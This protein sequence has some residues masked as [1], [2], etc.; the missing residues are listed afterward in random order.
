MRRREFIAGLGSA[1]A[2]PVV[3]R[4]QQP[5]MPVVAVLSGGGPDFINTDRMRAFREGLSD[6]GYIEGRNVMIE[7]CWASGRY[8]RLPEMATE[9]VRRQVAVIAALN[10]S[11]PGLA[12]KA[13]STRIPIV[14]QTGGDPVKDGLVANLNRP[15]GNVT[16]VSSMNAVQRNLLYTGITRGKRLVVLVGQKKAVA[17]AVRNVSGRRRWSKLSEWLHPSEPQSASWAGRSTAQRSTS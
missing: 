1:A 3:A 14:F 12:A 4:A 11:V 5:A 16:G 15:G 9:L 17:I 2:W 13:A 10:T 6:A 8:N 7:Y